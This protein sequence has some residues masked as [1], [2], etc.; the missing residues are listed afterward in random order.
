MTAAR[1]R[2]AVTALRDTE[3]APGD[4]VGSNAIAIG[5]TGTST[6]SARGVL[7]GNPHYPWQGARRFWQSQLT[8]PGQ[9]NVSGASL[10]GLPIVVIGHNTDVA[11]SHTVSTATTFGLY[12]VPIA[13]GSPTTYLVDGAPEQMTAQPVS[14]DVRNPDGSISTVR[15]TFWS[16]RYGPVITGFPGLPLPWGTT[17][18]VLRDAN[19]DNL[20][21]VNT[22]LGLGHARD[23]GDVVAALSGTLGMPWVNTVATDRAGHALYADIQAVPNITDDL[24]QRC[25]TALGKQVYPSTGLA[26]LAGGRSTCGWPTDADA[27]RPGLIGPSRLPSLT[28]SDYVTNSNDSAWLANPAAPLTGYPRVVGDIGTPR[29][30]RTQEG[31]LAVQRR[32]AGSD[33]LPGRG[34]TAATMRQVLFSDHS[35]VAE[36]AAASTAAMCASFAGGLAPSHSGPVDV[37]SGCAALASWDGRYTL[38]SRGSLL[39]ERFVVR[40]ASGST[41]PW[42]NPFDPTDPVHTPNTLATE[43][44]YVQQAFG[45]AA[46][47]LRAAG[48]PLDAPLGDYQSV[49]RDDQRI[50]IHGAP[51]ALGVLDVITPVWDPARGNTDVVHGSSFIQAVEFDTGGAPTAFTLLTYS[52]SSDPTS[53]HYADQTR[54]FSAGGWVRD[55]FT[56]A[57]I[58]SSPQ[59]RVQVLAG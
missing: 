37:A 4:A 50:P 39:F 33:G 49:T 51:H 13:A 53:A 57:E 52:Q 16:T 36:L 11:W 59:L 46:V 26:I 23:T 35:R 47:D 27:V 38:T 7:L 19:A 20:R 40:L 5:S 34:F 6:P 22:W 24:E 15:R 14:V 28:R 1:V 10:L 3:G 31:I 54:L 21:M 9:L 58:L 41:S 25:G 2:A 44:P 30:F 12:E 29:S 43:L 18:Y 48:I 32:L 56:E 45:D 8:I 55:R 42:Q 17:A